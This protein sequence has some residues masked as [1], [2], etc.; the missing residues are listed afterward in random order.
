MQR[1]TAK[2]RKQTDT[3]D[4]TSK[5]TLLPQRRVVPIRGMRPHKLNKNNL[6]KYTTETKKNI[7]TEDKEND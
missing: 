2:C 3:T 4:S 5:K 1:K 7:Y 6:D